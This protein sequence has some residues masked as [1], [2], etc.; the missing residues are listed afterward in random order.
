M[1]V[2]LDP[3][4]SRTG[5]LKEEELICIG[6]PLRVDATALS[7]TQVARLEQQKDSET[8]GQQKN[9]RWLLAIA[10]GIFLLESWLA[11]RAGRADAAPAQS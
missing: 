3:A 10:A 2:N 9:W 5:P 8:E 11:G 6:V 7:Q 1:A 4:E